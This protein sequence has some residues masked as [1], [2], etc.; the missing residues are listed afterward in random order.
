MNFRDFGLPLG[1]GRSLILTGIR[2][3]WLWLLIGGAALC[4][5][6]VLYR[7][8]RRLVSRRMGLALLSLRIAAALALVAALFEPMARLTWREAVRGRLILG[9]D[10]SESMSTL[11]PRR[12]LEER[13]ALA[14]T[15]DLS[16][17]ERPEDL[18]RRDVERRLLSGAWMK[19]ISSDRDVEAI[20]F[21]KRPAAA[22]PATLAEMLKKGSM[23]DDPAGQVT[24]WQPVLE[25][26]LQGNDRAPVVAVVLLSDGRWNGAGDPARLADRLGAQGIPVYPVLIG[27]TV[28]PRDAAIAAVKAPDGVYKG[29]VANVEVTL[30][31][32]APEGVDVP[33]T[34]DRPGAS[35]LRK[36]VRTPGDGSRPVV[37]F[38]VALDAA[39]PQPLTVAVGPVEGDVRP[40]NDRRTVTVSVVDDK[41]HVLLVDG[42]ARWEFQYLRN[43][44]VRDPRV[45]VDAIVLQQPK[46][47]STADNTYK[48]SWPLRRAEPGRP[49]PLGAFDVIVLGDVAPEMMAADTWTRLD[50][51]VAERGGTLVLASGPKS[52]LALS[53]N[54]ASRKLL[55]V[56]EPRRAPVDADTV[57]PERPALPAG[58]SLLPAASGEA[59]PMLQFA[60]EPDKNRAL[61]SALPRLPW[62]VSGKAKPTAT[63]LA[64]VSGSVKPE[65]AAAIAAMPYGL[66]KVLWVGTDGT[67]RWR[68]RVGDAYHHRFWGQLVRWAASGKL[69]AGNRLVRF[70]PERPKV[71]EDDS[72]R[73][74]V[75]F[76]EDAPGVG[77]DLLVAARVF[78]AGPPDR[79]GGQPR[80]QG[81]AIAIVP[82]RARGGEPRAFEGLAPALPA[83]R[84]IVRLDVP[85]LVEAFKAEGP[86]PEAVLEVAP[87]ETPERI[88]L[89]AL[90]EPLDRLASATGGRVFADH[91]AGGLP[92]LLRTRSLEKVR[93]EE[94]TLWDRPWALLLFFAILTAEWS[95]R[96]QA[97]LP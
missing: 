54:E 56:V 49:D 43:A 46:A 50:A 74:Q 92:S 87:R 59:W 4:L 9:V 44:L 36:L 57:D 73:L 88:E 60:A 58:V 71:S 18:S 80:A 32:D 3:G 34:L 31:I 76:A 27:S 2:S 23:P 35:P 91:Q 63:V 55:P 93:T 61:W 78:K 39:G 30:K 19:A 1:A 28:P 65:D 84:Y 82:L 47:L 16:P 29:D 24:D 13:M 7:Y 11:D 64:A 70:G 69:A 75:R 89:A 83:G 40:D 96:K 42:E 45:S 6:L 14:R 95:L 22:N 81:E 26:A 67:W 5:V 97:G 52:Y 79:P 8:E 86:A 72:A 10:L 90:R 41:A 33:V 51:Y 17:A 20:G 15:L 77:P 94:T 68:H 12:S 48:G 38:R 25:A 62:V 85:Q 21:A 66:G 37:M 53:G